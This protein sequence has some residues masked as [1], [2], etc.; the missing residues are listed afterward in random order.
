MTDLQLPPPP[1]RLT[2]GIPGLDAILRG[3]LFKTGIYVLMGQP[4][5]GKTICANQIAFHHVANGGRALYVT[6]L[7]ETHGR[8]IGQMQSLDFFDPTALGDALTFLNGFTAIESEGLSGLLNLLRSAVRQQ[9]ASLLVLDGMITAGALAKSGVD[10]KKFINELQTWVGVI[11]CTVLFLTSS[12]HETLIMPEHTMVDGIIELR[13][14]HSDMRSVRLLTVTKFRGS[15][16]IDGAHTYAITNGGVVVYPR[17]EGRYVPAL[18]DKTDGVRAGFGVEKLDHMLRGGFARGSTTLLL[19][20]TGTGKTMLGLHYLAAGATVGE[21]S[22]HFG[23]Y[24]NP[25]DLTSKADRIGLRFSEHSKAGRLFISWRPA[26]ELLLDQVADELL[27][28]VREH[29]IKRLFIDGLVGFK[30]V[31]FPNRT[32][33]FFAVLS[34]ELAARGVTTVITEEATELFA[35]THIPT[36]GVSAIFHNIIV[37]SRAYTGVNYIRVL[38][39]IKTRDSEHDRTAYEFEITDGGLRL[40]SR[41]ESADS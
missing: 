27:R 28:I 7:A 8:M 21:P 26:G 5:V 31:F 23:F 32:P 18:P 20:A 9:R 2:T 14:Q 36:R 16:F 34:E 15:A 35:T 39:V 11:G 37:L 33:G 3:G 10:Y 12:T 29:R 6:L 1:P 30:E 19:G 38:S 40:G 22:L 17:L 25:N 4:G 24:E 41:V 13:T